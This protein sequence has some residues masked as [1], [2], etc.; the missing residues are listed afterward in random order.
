MSNEVYFIVLSRLECVTTSQQ[1]VFIYSPPLKIL[2][3]VLTQ[4]KKRAVKTS[5]A[6]VLWDYVI[7][8]YRHSIG[9]DSGKYQR[10]LI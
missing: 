5:F 3:Q 1:T 4:L 9:F 2:I 7:F 8:N 10:R 6:S